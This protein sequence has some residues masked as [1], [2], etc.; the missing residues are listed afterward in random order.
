MKS[1]REI[2]FFSTFYG[3]NQ[4]FSK[5]TSISNYILLKFRTYQ[6]ESLFFRS[7]NCLPQILFIIELGRKIMPIFFVSLSGNDYYCFYATCISKC[8]ILLFKLQTVR[9]KCDFFSTILNLMDFMFFSF[10][11]CLHWILMVFD[12]AILLWK[13]LAFGQVWRYISYF[14][15]YKTIF[16]GP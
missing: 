10:K 3:K 9:W 2:R 13:N 6:I 1:F 4:K 8:T 7:V 14:H 16:V 11:K 12:L 5:M 15:Y